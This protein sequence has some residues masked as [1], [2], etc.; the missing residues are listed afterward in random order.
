MEDL[1][2]QHFD[3]VD[4]DIRKKAPGYS[5]FMDQKVTPDVLSFIADCV[6]NFLGGKEPH[7]TFV[8]T[9]I[10]EFP[11]FIKNTVAIFGK[12][13]P[14]NETTGS[15][16]DKFIAQPLKTLAF[17]KILEEK[18]IGIKNTYTVLKPDILEYISRNERNA[19]H[20]LVVYIEKVLSDSGFIDELESYMAK[21]AA[22]T[23]SNEDF[24]TLKNDFQIFM[25]GFT[26][27]NG[28]TEINR[29]FPKVLNPY[30]AAYKI[31][32]TEKGHMT[33]GRFI[34]SDLMYN[35][36]NFRDIGKDKTVS[37]QE[38]LREIT[39]LP[40]V[41]IYRVQKAKNIIKRHHANSEVRDSLAIGEATQVHHIFPEHG[42]PEISD[43]LENLI[44]LTPQQHNTRAHPDNKT[45]TIGS[46][47]QKDCLL[48][49]IDSI[50]AS[51]RKGDN[52]YAKERF[53][54]VI[55]TGYNF[56]LSTNTSFEEL[57]E[58]IRKRQTPS[59]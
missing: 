55:N 52:L 59:G 53:I 50:I 16:Y 24:E 43:Y 2:K 3:Q 27:I 21:A 19:L 11:Y 36:K 58:I 25:R 12:P 37:R 20:F 13:S 51:I 39:E 44:L 32:G 9:D 5:R 29:I 48:S 38:M 33:P 26:E 46:E 15:E 30:A 54:H 31:P 10:W 45:Q 17:A 23:L 1:L 28:D 8:I 7:T 47:Y 56:N 14:E 6:V 49:K 41:V 18:K 42:F 34:Y 40:E 22:N 35:R 57:K 4:L